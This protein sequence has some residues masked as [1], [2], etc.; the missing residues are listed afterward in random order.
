MTLL[1]LFLQVAG[2]FEAGLLPS[3]VNFWTWFASLPL[4]NAAVLSEAGLHVSLV[5]FNGWRHLAVEH[6]ARQVFEVWHHCQGE[7]EGLCEELLSG[8]LQP[9]RVHQDDWCN[10]HLNRT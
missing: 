9:R 8:H 1:S 6:V 2:S 5:L 7:A 3:C 4:W 10:E